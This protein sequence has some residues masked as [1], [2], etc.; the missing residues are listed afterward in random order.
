MK[1]R[2]QPVVTLANAAKRH[3]KGCYRY[4]NQKRKVQEGLPPFVSDTGYV[5]LILK[6]TL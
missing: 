2:V 1:A 3:E 5:E 6:Y 4:L